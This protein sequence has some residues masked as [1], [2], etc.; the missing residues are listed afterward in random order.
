M[1]SP[2]EKEKK[3]EMNE[4]KSKM[5]FRLLCRNADSWPVQIQKKIWVAV[6]EKPLCAFLEPPTTE[7]NILFVHF[8]KTWKWC[9]FILNLLQP[10]ESQEKRQKSTSVLVGQQITVWISFW[11]S[12]IEKKQTNSKIE[13][14]NY[15]FL[16]LLNK[17]LIKHISYQLL[18]NIYPDTNVLYYLNICL[19][20]SIY[21]K[22]TVRSLNL[23]YYFL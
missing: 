13:V 4:T 16:K 20:G 7:S 9:I 14:Y 2:L 11:I 23:R 5:C 6:S 1:V 8:W 22:K 10:K 12:E 17:D 21:R 19:L 15:Y 3:M 18:E